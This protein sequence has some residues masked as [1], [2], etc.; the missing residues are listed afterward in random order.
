MDQLNLNNKLQAAVSS[1]NELEQKLETIRQ[2][3]KNLAEQIEEGR[4]QLAQRETTRRSIADNIKYREQ[5]AQIKALEDKIKEKEQSLSGVVSNMDD[6]SEDMNS[7]Q[8]E[9]ENVKSKV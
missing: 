4:D 9:Y 3:T 6:I 2:E 7:I 1:K 5:L 8:K